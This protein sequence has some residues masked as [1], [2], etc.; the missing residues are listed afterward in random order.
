[1]SRSEISSFDTLLA[2]RANA[3]V[4]VKKLAGALPWLKAYSRASSELWLSEGLPTKRNEA[5]KYTNIAALAENEITLARPATL[6]AAPLGILRQPDSLA[7]LVFVNGRFSSELS[8]FSPEKNGVHIQLLSQT[9][10]ENALEELARFSSASL[11]NQT[12]FGA[13]N[14]ELSEEA[15]LIRITKSAVVAQQP[16][17]VYYLSSGSDEMAFQMATP[18]IYVYSEKMSEAALLEVYGAGNNRHFMTN[19]V[20]DLVLDEGARLSHC[21]LQ[22]EGP[23]TYHFSQTQ[24][25]LGRGS[26]LETHQVSLGAKLSRHDL[27]VRLNGE[28]AEAVVNGLYIVQNEQHVDNHTSIEHVLGNTVSSQLY[29]GILDDR[30]RAVFNGRVWIHQDAQKAN[31]VQLNKNLLLSAKA[32]VDSKPELEI[33][34]DDVKASHG[35]T[36]GQMDAEQLFYFQTRAVDQQTA[37]RMIALGFAQDVVFSMKNEALKKRVSPFIEEKF[38]SLGA[39]K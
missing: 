14:F 4:G 13:L 39:R 32:E 7:E 17:T 26:W 36:V 12:V 22:I 3:P 9:G 23:E 28:A 15:V 10:P 11:K 24:A 19:A 30:S 37:E 1:M 31:A 35:A 34:A 2:N 25:E 27:S 8:N 5:W 21:K 29:K 38:F 18:R 33:Y 6:A 20:T 16:I